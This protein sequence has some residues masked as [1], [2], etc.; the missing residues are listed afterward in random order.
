MFFG[1]IALSFALFPFHP[2]HAPQAAPQKTSR[3]CV[4]LLQ[5]ASLADF[6]D[7]SD[8]IFMT[9]WC[10]RPHFC[11]ILMYLTWFG[12][13]FSFF[14]NM[15]S[16]FLWKC[17]PRPSRKHNSEDRHKAFLMTNHT[18]STSKRPCRCV[19][20]S[21]RLLSAPCP[22]SKTSTNLANMCIIATG[23]FLGRL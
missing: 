17:A 11:D 9:S 10:I 18:F 1:L 23:G 3:I 7:A 15:F 13:H 19:V 16:W 20:R 14:G 6:T 8:T 21:F 5:V 12:Q 22:P 2:L 4:L